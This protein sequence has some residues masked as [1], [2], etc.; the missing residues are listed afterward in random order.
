MKKVYRV[1]ALLAA[2]AMLGGCGGGGESSSESESSTA[3]STDV[4][5]AESSETADAP[6]YPVVTDGSITLEYWMPLDATAAQV[7]S[8]YA[9]NTAY[10]KAQEVTGINIEFIHPTVGEAQSQFNLLI[11]SGDLP[12]M[13]QYAAFYSGGV[14]QGYEDGAYVDGGMCPGLL[15]SDQ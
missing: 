15:C 9:E 8:S 4:S 13:I 11:V 12:D 10:Q 3:S 7:V 6:L 2:M 5:Q 1:F 14:Y